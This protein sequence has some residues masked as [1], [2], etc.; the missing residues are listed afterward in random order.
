[1]KDTYGDHTVSAKATAGT[2]ILLDWVSFPLTK[3][4]EHTLAYVRQ[5]FSRRME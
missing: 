3:A 4:W 5:T 1:M 2:F